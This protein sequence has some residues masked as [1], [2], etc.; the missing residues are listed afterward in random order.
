MSNPKATPTSRTAPEPTPELP[1][2]IKEALKSAYQTYHQAA[3]S[4]SEDRP[5]AARTLAN[6]GAAGRHA[7]W[8]IKVLA[9]PT[10]LT[11]ER[12]RQIIKSYSDGA[13]P[14]VGA[15]PKYVA[16]RK[17]PPPTPVK[18]VHLTKREAAQLRKLAPDAKENKGS[19]PLNSKYRKASEQ[20]SELLKK[21]HTRGVTWREMSDATREWPAWPIPDEVHEEIREAEEAGEKD[22]YPPTHRIAGL[23]MRAARHGYGKGAPPSIKPYQRKFIYDKPKAKKPETSSSK[24]STSGT[25]KKSA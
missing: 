18:R 3:E 22:P 7:G 10:G 11:A 14:E 20:F 2:H 4:R 21:H 19:L 17:A 13:T 24:K 1:D 16:P 6:L 9:E 12:L 15:F 25:T 5:A 8:S 23:R